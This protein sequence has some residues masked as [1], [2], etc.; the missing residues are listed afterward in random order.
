M[1]DRLVGD[2][3]DAAGQVPGNADSWRRLPALRCERSPE[4]EEVFGCQLVEVAPG[5]EDKVAQHR[6]GDAAMM[7]ADAESVGVVFCLSEQVRS[8]RLTCPRV[9]SG[10]SGSARTGSSDGSA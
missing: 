7:R 8:E 10:R 5:V 1:A 2:A 4:L 6:Q 9:E 3:G